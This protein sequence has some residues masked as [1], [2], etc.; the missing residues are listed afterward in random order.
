MP[1]GTFHGVAILTALRESLTEA[2]TG[3]RTIEQGTYLSGIL[4]A[5]QGEGDAQ[6]AIGAPRVEASIV[7]VKPNPASPLEP[8]S[9]AFHD[10]T[11]EVRIVRTV[12]RDHAL[13]PTTRDWLRGQT[14]NDAAAIR[15]AFG[16]PDNLDAT[17][18]GAPTGIIS[19]RCRYVRGQ[20][21]RIELDAEQGRLVSRHTLQCSVN[22]ITWLPSQLSP[23]LWLR[24]DSGVTLTDGTQT[25]SAWAD[26]SGNSVSLTAN[27]SPPFTARESTTLRS[28]LTLADNGYFTISNGDAQ[29]AANS[30]FE[31][32][33]VVKPSAAGATTDYVWHSR[34]FSGDLNGW[35]AGLNY[36]SSRLIAV[37]DDGANSGSE[38][39]PAFT[40]G[41]LLVARWRWVDADGA[42]TM[43][44][45]AVS[46][47]ESTGQGS[48]DLTTS[49][50]H[51][52]FDDASI[53][54][55]GFVGEAYEFIAN[56]TGTLWT[57]A[58][59]SILTQYVNARYGLALSTV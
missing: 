14:A 44:G 15:S 21:G 29:P 32:L 53:Q 46:V 35:Y 40:D 1:A 11:I 18:S 6:R 22:E 49:A 9:H 51:G 31:I 55:G 2:L 42:W 45:N 25:V 20:P 3:T 5:D 23:S 37:W 27:G 7:D 54:S 24:A 34:A 48:M 33:A 38:T 57:P 8:C 28:S 58:Q 19:G 10:L 12:T 39:G 56:F 50:D 17:S 26:Q 30:D 13:D 4:D 47:T 59:L 36:T 16:Y 41:A 52:L 43:V